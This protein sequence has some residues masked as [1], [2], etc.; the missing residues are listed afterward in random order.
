MFMLHRILPAS[1]ALFIPALA[2]ASDV[3]IFPNPLRAERSA[4]FHV[5]AGGRDVFVETFKDVAIAHFS[6]NG[7]IPVSVRSAHPLG[8]VDVSP[9]AAGI[10]TQ[11]TGDTLAFRLAE[12]RHVVVE[13]DGRRLFIFADTIDAAAPKL[14][15][16]GVRSVLDFGVDRTGGSLD[17]AR[18]QRAIDEVATA[19]GTLFIPPGVYLTGSLSLRS[20][21]TLYLAAGAR[22]QGSPR[23]EDYPEVSNSSAVEEKGAAVKVSRQRANQ[24]YSQLLLVENVTNVRLAGPGVI[25][26]EGKIIRDQ[27][28]HAFLL[29]L[30]NASQITVEGVTL[31]NSAAWNTHLLHSDQVTFRGVKVV[32]DRAVSNSDG[33]D[34]DSAQDVLI[35]RC[36]LYAGDDAFAIKTSG[37]SGLLRNA[38]RITVRGCV[39]LTK[40]SA[41]K[42]GTETLAEAMRDIT[43]ADNDI[44]EADRAMSLYCSDGA[45]FE[46]IRF[47][48]N[49]VERFFPDRKQRTIEFWVRHRNGMQAGGIRD[50]LIADTTVEVDSPNASLIEGFDAD[51]GVSGVR[52]VNYTVAGRNCR[53]A[54]DARIEM[55]KFVQPPAFSVTP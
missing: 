10:V 5:T 31:R 27:G 32:N 24:T 16:K 38:E 36:F 13:I 25:D 14:G 30:R 49:R 7:E 53:S 4:D 19:H 46:R 26:G 45:R 50:V 55:N 28:K 9:H 52:F 44:V 12:P 43:F 54:A 6:F 8:R 51:H 41:M 2:A 18:L 23:A 17:T 20:N 33:I 15:Q 48:R 34:P 1:L 22:L 11:Q 35:D 40:K 42:L 39:I 21:L 37:H 29:R 3:E 47:E